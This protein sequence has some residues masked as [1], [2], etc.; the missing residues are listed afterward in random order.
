MKKNRL[1]YKRKKLSTEVINQIIMGHIPQNQI[2][3]LVGP[4]LKKK[5]DILD[6]CINLLNIEDEYDAVLKD[7]FIMAKEI[8]LTKT[9]IKN[10]NIMDMQD[11]DI[12]SQV[13]DYLVNKNF[14]RKAQ[15]LFKLNWS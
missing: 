3:D 2:E 10:S 15:M 6:R 5:L 4:I 14:D 1:C 11:L 13:Y 8:L 12:L 7:V 9:K